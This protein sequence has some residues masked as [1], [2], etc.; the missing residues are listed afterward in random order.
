MRDL[1]A[2]EAQTKVIAQWLI[3]FAGRRPSEAAMEVTAYSPHKRRQ[4]FRRLRQL[5]CIAYTA[6]GWVAIK[7]LES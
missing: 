5:E 2:I 1:P 6:H 7:G 3:S 4:M